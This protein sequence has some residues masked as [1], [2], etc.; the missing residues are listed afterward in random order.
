MEFSISTKELCEIQ[1]LLFPCV[2]A[3]RRLWVCTSRP[4]MPKAS[5]SA[6]RR[7]P[8]GPGGFRDE[9]A[10][11]RAIK[12]KV[13]Y[14]TDGSVAIVPNVSN[15]N[16][17]FHPFLTRPLAQPRRVVPSV[18]NRT[19]QHFLNGERAGASKAVGNAPYATDQYQRTLWAYARQVG[20]SATILSLDGNCGSEY[21]RYA[22]PKPCPAR[23]NSCS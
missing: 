21:D 15:K 18:V 3:I 7:C 2:R 17:E 23:G 11:P 12:I 20:F 9:S 22:S 13:R 6:L 10:R 1:Y 5:R 19:S 8:G 14:S 4:L 16:K